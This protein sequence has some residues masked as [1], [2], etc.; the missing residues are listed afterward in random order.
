[1]SH[2][3]LEEHLRAAVAARRADR[4]EDAWRHLLAAEAIC[5]STGRRRDLVTTLAGMA[6]LHRD[7]ADFA[8]A[9]PLYEEAVV[10]AQQLRNP[11][12]L[13][14]AL[15]HL[16]EVHLELR[17]FERAQQHLRDAIDLYRLEPDAPPLELA[18]AV[19]PLAICLERQGAVDESR[20]FWTEARDL[21]ASLGI[22]PGV[23][24]CEAGLARLPG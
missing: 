9:L 18:N 10:H 20:R 23:T 4:A 12:V 15:R 6:Q 24:E 14:R 13:A 17:Q 22:E 1:M 2:P 3:D 8:S 19:R 16:G 5:R 21:Y 11:T 7:A